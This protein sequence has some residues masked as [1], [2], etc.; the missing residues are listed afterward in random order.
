MAACLAGDISEDCIGYYKIP[1]GD[2]RTYYDTPEKLRTFDPKIRLIAPIEDPKSFSEA[3][4]EL[5]SLRSQCDGLNSLILKGNLTSAGL[6]ILSIL[7]RVTVVGQF[8]IRSLA[9]SNASGLQSVSSRM[10]DIH[11]ELV[12]KMNQCDIMLGQGIRGDLGTITAAQYQIL[13][14]IKELT[15]LFDEFLQTIPADFRV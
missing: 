2:R 10:E 12:I 6:E 4:K 8:V 11:S 15:V 14:E 1:V 7:P 9:N 5:V 3:K 13:G